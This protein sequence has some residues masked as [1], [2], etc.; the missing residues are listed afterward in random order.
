VLRLAQQV[1][2]RQ[3]VRALVQSG[4]RLAR[5]AVQGFGV[6][7]QGAFLAQ[8]VLLV[9]FQARGFNLLNLV[10]EHVGAV[11]GVLLQVQE[12]FQFRAVC[13]PLPVK[14]GVLAKRVFVMREAVQQL[15]MAAYFQERKML[16]LPVDIRQQRAKLGLQRERDAAPV[17]PRHAAPTGA[18]FARERERA[19]LFPQVFRLQQRPDARGGGSVQRERGFDDSFV[20]VPPDVVHVHAAAQ[21]SVQRVQDNGFARAGFTGQYHQPVRK[22]EG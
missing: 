3:G 19:V 5:K 14:P 12:L 4:E 16:G 22:G 1:G 20:T 6:R 11:F 18:D 8:S 10:L 2:D 17:H 15:Q 7:Q 9:C 13:Q 21:H